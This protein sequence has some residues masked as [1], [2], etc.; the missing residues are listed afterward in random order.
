MGIANNTYNIHA[1]EVTAMGPVHVSEGTVVR[2]NVNLKRSM[3]LSS[4]RLYPRVL[5]SPLDIIS[6]PIT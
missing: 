4:N 5:S 6:M 2:L 1:I 3:I